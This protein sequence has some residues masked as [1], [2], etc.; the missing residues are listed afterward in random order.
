MWVGLHWKKLSHLSTYLGV[1]LKSDLSWSEHITG[2]C[3]KARKVL[4]LLY[5][6]FY[7]V[8]SPDTIKQLYISLV[9]PHLEYAAQLWDPYTHRNTKRLETVQKFALKVIARCWDMNY[10]ESLRSFNIPKLIDRRRV[11]KLS[12]VYRI[13]YGLVL[14]STRCLCEAVFCLWLTFQSWHHLLPLCSNE[15]PISLICS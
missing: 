5:R 2:V 7:T 1:L 4:A 8:S 13:L 10:E 3:R 15:L 6:H 11:H 9:R 14:L 12:L